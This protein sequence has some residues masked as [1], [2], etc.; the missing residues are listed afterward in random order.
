[1]FEC[2]REHME[3]ALL[4]PPHGTVRVER[5]R[6]PL[7]SAGSAVDDIVSGALLRL[8]DGRVE[9]VPAIDGVVQRPSVGGGALGLYVASSLDA[10]GRLVAAPRS[11]GQLD[12]A[13]PGGRGVSLIAPGALLPIP[14]AERTVELAALRPHLQVGGVAVQLEVAQAD[15]LDGV[16]RLRVCDAQGTLLSEGDVASIFELVGLSWQPWL[17]AVQV[18]VSAPSCAEGGLREALRAV[19]VPAGQLRSSHPLCMRVYESVFVGSATVSAAVLVRMAMGLLAH[20]ETE[21][22]ERAMLGVCRMVERM[23]AQAG[24]PS[25]EEAGGALQSVVL[26]VAEVCEAALRAAPS[27]ALSEATRRA[28]HELG[29]AEGVVP[30]GSSTERLFASLSRHLTPLVAGAAAPATPEIASGALTLRPA[31]GSG[32]PAVPPPSISAPPAWPPPAAMRPTPPPPPPLQGRPLLVAHAAPARLAVPA[33]TPARAAPPEAALRA[34]P[35]DSPETLLLKMEYRKRMRTGALFH[36]GAASLGHVDAVAADASCTAPL[37]PPGGGASAAASSDMARG[38]SVGGWRG[39]AADSA[40]GISG[41]GVFSS[42]KPGLPGG[43]GD[44]AGAGALASGVGCGGGGGGGGGGYAALGGSISVGGALGGTAGGGGWRPADGSFLELRSRAAQAAQGRA[45]GAGVSRVLATQQTHE[46][47]SIADPSR[48]MALFD[49][50]ARLRATPYAAEAASYI[51]SSGS[52]RDGHSGALKIPA[53][54]GLVRDGWLRFVREQIRWQLGDDRADDRDAV[55]AELCDAVLS[56]D[57]DFK[58]WVENMGGMRP[59]GEFR[60]TS[61]GMAEGHLGDVSNMSHILDAATRLEYVLD[62]LVFH[63]L[64]ETSLADPDKPQERWGFRRMVEDIAGSCDAER[65]IR[66]AQEFFRQLRRVMEER[67]SS[68]AKAG[69]PLELAAR[70]KANL[71]RVFSVLREDQHLDER[72]AV[73]RAESLAQIAELRAQI[74]AAATSAARGQKQSSDGPRDG[75]GERSGPASGPQVP[76]P[77]AS[78][79]TFPATGMGATAM[80]TALVRKQ[81]GDANWAGAKNALAGEPC[82]WLTLFGKCEPKGG[83]SCEACDAGARKAEAKLADAVRTAYRTAAKS[84]T[85]AG[86]VVRRFA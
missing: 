65:T 70:T 29:V 53:S 61:G 46:A 15:E 58:V 21:V 20:V 19:R 31:A 79:H 72:T 54:L 49:E 47:E 50:T 63:V 10:R 2:L 64:G 36:G 48:S 6:S 44:G 23:H 84:S 9:A 34:M 68:A 55:V 81:N 76:V 73:I 85:G 12:D 59:T 62:S 57:V 1:M 39:P 41:A 22:I 40:G 30:A 45:L 86:Q 14:A 35:D 26:Q 78:G 18:D 4:Q 83:R 66:G 7:T 71:Q 42:G 24:V 32:V 51:L 60:C 69:Q 56:L 37:C 82:P 17:R 75:G 33:A 5:M 74:A 43:G 11:V 25:P 28:L 3:A 27:A 16:T 52:L 13:T 80:L 67:R 77:G 8:H 38:T